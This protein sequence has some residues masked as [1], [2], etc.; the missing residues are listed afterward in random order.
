M[1]QFLLI[2]VVLV[3]C[4]GAYMRSEQPES[5]NQFLDVLRAPSTPGTPGAATTTTPGDS[6]TAPATTATAP[7]KPA[8]PEYVNPAPGT[9]IHSSHIVDVAQPSQ[10]SHT[11]KVFVPPNPLPAQTAWI[12][13]TSDGRTFRNVVVEKVEADRVTIFHD[14]GSAVVDIALLPDEIQGKLNYDSQ[15]AAQASAAR[16]AA[17]AGSPAPG[18]P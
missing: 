12:W 13:T 18:T 7:A 5:W 16:S 2:V 8:A 9:P 1:N 15:L 11:A 17:S 10:E 14:Q 6:T 4:G 3:L